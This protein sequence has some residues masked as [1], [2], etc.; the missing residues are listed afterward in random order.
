[1]NTLQPR[2]QTNEMKDLIM[3]SLKSPVWSPVGLSEA[4]AEASRQALATS[5]HSASA[6]LARL[7]RQIARPARKVRAAEPHIE[8]YAPSG[9]PEGA[10]YLDGKLVGWVPGVRRL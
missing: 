5:L 3:S 6:L 7:A 8:F 1:M 4:L 2:L 9:A 10:L